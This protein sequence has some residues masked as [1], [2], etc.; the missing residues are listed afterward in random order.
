MQISHFCTPLYHQIE[1]LSCKYNCRSHELEVLWYVV[2]QGMANINLDRLSKC[3]VYMLKS[4]TFFFGNHILKEELLRK[5][6][7]RNPDP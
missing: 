1:I 6:L 3:L 5:Q 4:K 2:H 7:L